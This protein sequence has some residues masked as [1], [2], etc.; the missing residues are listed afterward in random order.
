M[1]ATGFRPGGQM[2]RDLV[3]RLL[4]GTYTFSDIW[5]ESFP[6]VSLFPTALG[7]ATVGAHAPFLRVRHPADDG[8]RQC[9]V[10]YADDGARYAQTTIEIPTRVS[11]DDLRSGGKSRCFLG[12]WEGKR[13]QTCMYRYRGKATA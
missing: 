8:V 13:W 4:P 10:R 6:L 2:P 12:Q 9:G 1:I 3:R 11:F 7:G 5:N